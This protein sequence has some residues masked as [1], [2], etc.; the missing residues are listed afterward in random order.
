MIRSA[1]TN[2]ATIRVVGLNDEISSW[3]PQS[4]SAVQFTLGTVTATQSMDEV[5]TPT[6]GDGQ[7]TGT[8]TTTSSTAK[9][10]IIIVVVVVVVVVV[11]AAAVALGAFFWIRSRRTPVHK[12]T[13]LGTGSTLSMADMISN[14]PATSSSNLA[15]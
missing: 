14:S 13:E 1:Y 11:V 9:T 6:G 2:A 8:T 12:P 4:G 5:P 10:T 3:I 7:S 15:T